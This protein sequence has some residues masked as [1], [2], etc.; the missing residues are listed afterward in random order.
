[1]YAVTGITGR[2]GG[3]V[4]Q[5]LL[6]LGAKIRAVVRDP[7]KA[8][9]F[10]AQGAEVAVVDFNDIDALTQAFTEVEG[11][12]VMI[13][14]YFAPAPDFPET[15]AVLAA[16]SAALTAAQ[17][18]KVVALSS[19]GAQHTRGL[20]LVTQSHLLEEALGRLNLPV[21]CVR[22]GWFME[23][24]EWDIAPA[25]EKGE[26]PSHLQPLDRP[27]PMVA[28]EDIGRV[29]GETLLQEWQGHRVIELEGPRRY[30]PND[31]AAALSAALQKPVRASAVPREHW[32][33]DFEASGMPAGRTEYRA[34]MVDGFNSGWIEFEQPSADIYPGKVTLETVIA[35]MAAKTS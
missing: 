19:I 27:I 25:R 10:V 33:A 26:F 5:T 3:G 31:V 14:P 21:A 8:Q 35:R 34:E 32:T 30:S 9:Q 17:P 2:V 11:V 12:F 28:T 23:N 16:L 6:A 15:R 4:A 22:P 1:M 29:C 13:P 7:Q 20:G 24:A 18:G